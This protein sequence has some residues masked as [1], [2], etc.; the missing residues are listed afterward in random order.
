MATDPISAEGFVGRAHELGLVDAAWAVA[1]RGRGSLTVVSGEAGIGKTRFCEE[2][3]D[4]AEAAGLRVVTARCW[5]DGGAPPLWPWQPILDELCGG[6]AAD[7]LA[8]DAGHGVVDRDRFARFAA[9]TDRLAEACA[10]A[11]V[12]LVVD[13]VHAADAGTLLLIRFVARSLGRLPLALVLSRRRHEPAGG[14]EARLLDEIEG[15]A[16]AVALHPFDPAEATA[17]LSA[18]GL[19]GIAPDLVAAVVRVTGG[20]PLFL[21]RVAALGPPRPGEALPSGVRTAIDQAR[22]RLDPEVRRVLG[23]G[24]VLGPVPLVAETAA[25]AGTDPIS[26]LDAL[27]AATAAGLV[28]AEG[29]ERFRFTHELVRAA[30]ED[31]LA[32]AARLDAHARAASVVTAGAS[33]VAGTGATPERLARRAHHALAAA[34]RSAA[35]AQ[36]AVAACEV[37]AEAMVHSFAYEQADALLS[38]AVALHDAP[39]LGP[40]TGGL[41]V[42]WAQA[43]L[44]CG[45]MTEARV[46]FDRAATVAQSEEDPRLL[47]EA[48]LG[49]GGHWLNEHRTPVDKARVLGLQRAALAA[50]PPSDPSDPAG[51]A[52]GGAEGGP[53]DPDEGL[54]C[55]LTARLAAEAVFEG[56]PLEPLHEA[57]AAARRSGDPTALAEALS[58]GH[59]AL[60]D[61]DHT[62]SRLAMAD[63]LVRVASEAGLG[64][65]ALMGLCWRAVDLFHLG[66]PA[67]ERALE[68][69]RERANALACQN[70]LYIVD[71]MDVML[72]IRQGRLDEAERAA[73]RCYELGEAVGEVDTLGYMSTHLVCIRW[74]QGRDA[75]LLEAAEEVAASP[76]LIQAEFALRASAVAISARAGDRSRARAA[77]DRL[78]A[79]GLATLPQSSTWMAGMAAIVEAAAVLGDEERAREAHALLTPF[80]DLPVIASTGVVCVGSVERFLG[81]AAGT[82]GDPEAAVAHLERAVAANQ[83]L[84]NR[85][86]VALTRADLAAALRDRAAGGGAGSTGGPAADRARACELLEQAIPEATA[87]GMMAR[88]AA[89]Q[90]ELSA[91]R[92]RAA[93]AAPG[94]GSATATAPGGSVGSAGSTASAARAGERRPRRGV[95]RRE[96]SRWVI[97]LDGRRVRVGD[98]VGMSYLADLLTHPGQHIPALTLAAF[99]AAPQGS[100]RHDVLDDEA[101]AAYAARARELGDELARAEADNDVVRCERLR[102]EL[103]ALVDEV[104]AATGLGRRSR[105]FADDGERARTSVR[106]AIKRAI[107]AIDDAEPALAEMLRETVTTGATCVYTADPRVAVTWVTGEDTDADARAGVSEP[108]AA[109]R[110]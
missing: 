12:C 87:M 92:G 96:G 59:H 81:I 105:A 15:E 36:A 56:A 93:S 83:R 17:F 52:A 8:S 25:V 3:T 19:D 37:A 30:L 74:C 84:G 16:T 10:R 100:S 76:T 75:E 45:R 39:G 33:V 95:V 64:V 49:L 24:A 62:R 4:R 47:A 28:T 85:P 71:V 26:V 61:P 68:D 44:R 94:T 43:A 5:V 31:G 103:D 20:H 9:V 40:P 29:T 11:P 51:A 60:F 41:L 2:A 99:G 110:S 90:A 88:A 104:E 65:L 38:A 42:A 106:K 48:A 32:A 109:A 34:P 97:A 91:L 55:R 7:L 53:P 107:D 77:L 63:E 57:L 58:L 78:V 14:T 86:L 13:D 70:V 80:A 54:R 22:D 79:D 98:L 27:A 1:S 69:L 23:A 50:L 21:Q 6:D 102:D 66:D 72:L 67:A 35:D 18:H 46:R 82:Y 101:R 89:W 108:G 73:G